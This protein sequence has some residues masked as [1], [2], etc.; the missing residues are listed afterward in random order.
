MNFLC[1]IQARKHARLHAIFQGNSEQAACQAVLLEL[2]PPN[3]PDKYPMLCNFGIPFEYNHVR[4][5]IQRDLYKYNANNNHSTTIKVNLGNN[6]DTSLVT[7]PWSDTAEGMQQRNKKTK[8]VDEIVKALDGNLNQ[9]EVTCKHFL[10]TLACDNN[11]RQA[12]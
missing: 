3:N 2:G 8:F 10:E 7:I 6:R 11:F 9:P 5:A 4:N 12:F 1:E